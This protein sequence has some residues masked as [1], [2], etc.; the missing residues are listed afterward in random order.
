MCFSSLK[1]PYIVKYV[2]VFFLTV[3]F[4]LMKSSYLLIGSRDP[5]LIVAG[6]KHEHLL[7]SLTM[8]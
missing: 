2:A 7:Y 8:V 3:P 1:T 4:V 6:I 5:L